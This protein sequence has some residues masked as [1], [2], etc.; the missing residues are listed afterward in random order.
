[1]KF[2]ELQLHS[3]MMRGIEEAGFTDC[4]PVQ[5]KTFDKTLT[6]R[7]VYVQS[8]TGS[9][10]TAAFLIT[11][12]NLFLEGKKF[13]N[14][15]A[16]V[17][18]PTRELAVQ[19]EKDAKILGKFCGMKIG[20]FFGGVG[21]DT[22]EK[23]LSKNLNLYIGTP[24]RLID[25]YKSGKMTLNDIDILVI[26]E[27]DRMFDMG[28]IPDIRYMVKKM[29]PATE[30]L[31]MLYS[32]TLSQRVKQL[33]WE[34]MNDPFEIEIEP[35]KVTVE[36]ITQEL[37]HVSKD[38]KFNLLLGVL[39]KYQPRSVLIFTN[40]KRLAEVVS[41]RL[42][43]NGIANE[44]ISGDLPQKKRLRIID[45]VKAGKTEVLVATDVAARG[46]HIE[47]LDMVINYD[48]P[49]DAQNYVHRIGRTA[50][51]GKSGRA[52]ALACE[53]YVYNL[54]PIET[55]IGMKIPAVWDYDKMLLPDESGGE[56]EAM[57]KRRA[58]TAA[59][60]AHAPSRAGGREGKR[61]GP[62]KRKNG[63]APAAAAA[64]SGCAKEK[65]VS[66]ADTARKPAAAREKHAAV[67]AASA[68]PSGADKQARGAR[69]GQ[70]S[71]LARDTAR[72]Q[73][74][75]GQRLQKTGSEG[76]PAMRR[77]SKD[78]TA[79]ERLE[80]YRQKYGEDF[81]EVKGEKG[82]LK[83]KRTVKDTLKKIVSLFKITG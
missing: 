72:G 37:Y 82:K 43:G 71:S 24:G 80:F 77:L 23:L 50:R 47:D 64:E 62:R 29:R 25:F 20:C 35:E 19:V 44:F 2:T 45:E 11:I 32:A 56:R 65:R 46:L 51:A 34:Y 40:T 36:T 67:A 57:R 66:A 33:A 69:S 30:R 16:L 76:S 39:Q 1:M 70:A 75:Q 68:K 27:A 83:K 28:F 48:L 31:T 3:D 14:K 58:R 10:K 41:Y 60:S 26:D 12:F 8:Q 52:V 7:D 73:R 4:T 42:E 79:E 53:E 59:D 55:L 81:F 17:I 6:G 9:G 5:E 38:Q 61:R 63:A 21:Y 15:K 78:A 13:T 49:D 18:V 74:L 54:E 22:Q